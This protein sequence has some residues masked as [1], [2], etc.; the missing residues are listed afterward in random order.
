MQ[1]H[2]HV[3]C[4]EFSSLTQGG[5]GIHHSVGGLL[6]SLAKRIARQNPPTLYL[7]HRL[8]KETTGVMLLAKYE[9]TGS[10]IDSVRKNNLLPLSSL[11]R[12][13]EHYKRVREMFKERKVIKKYWAIT[14]GIPNPKE[15]EDNHSLCAAWGKFHPCISVFLFI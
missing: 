7:V 2:L 11:L 3:S 15:G 5:P 1:F 8:D 4:V 12:N 9:L 6:G 13:L 10:P 14:K